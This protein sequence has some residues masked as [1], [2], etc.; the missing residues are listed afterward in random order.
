MVREHAVLGFSRTYESDDPLYTRRLWSEDIE[1]TGLDLIC[2]TAGIALVSHPEECHLLG[3]RSVVQAVAEELGNGELHGEPVL[4]GFLS[5][6]DAPRSVAF[7]NKLI[8][9]RKRMLGQS[10]LAHFVSEHFPLLRDWETTSAEAVLHR[11]IQSLTRG[12]VELDGN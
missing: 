9:A 10:R 6:Y 11:S 8:A 1:A 2:R 7:Q 12:G 3:R 4:R 5:D